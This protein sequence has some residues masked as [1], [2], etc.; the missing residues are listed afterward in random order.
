[1]TLQT[2]I[3][4]LLVAGSF[5]YAAWTL[6]PQAARR[7]L[8]AGLLCLPLPGRWRAYLQT[9]ARAAAGGCGCSGCDAVPPPTGKPQPVVFHPRSK[10]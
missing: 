7:G 9:M 8:A 1:M 3:V 2:V 4:A 6:L 10:R 5:A